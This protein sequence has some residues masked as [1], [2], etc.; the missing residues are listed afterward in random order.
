MPKRKTE[1]TAIKKSTKLETEVYDV[2]GKVVE[3]ISLPK[4]IFEAR[5]NTSLV[6]QAVR[7]Y[8]ANQRL[9]TAS[10]K[11]RGQVSGSTR[12]IYRQKGTGRARHGDIKAPIFIG[13]GIAHG[14]HPHDYNLTM[15]QKMRKM[16]LYG[17]ITDKF[18]NDRIKVI[19]GLENMP[20]KTKA[21]LEI[22][23][24]LGYIDKKDKKKSTVLLVIP[25]KM[26]N[27]YL[28]GRNLKCL[29]VIEVGQLNTYE[30]LTRQNL[31]F[32]K[33]AIDKLSGQKPA[34]AKK[35]IKKKSV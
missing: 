2:S 16:A 22:L 13:G 18:K 31:L 29:M 24:V 3:K 5:V 4:E 20:L 15:P 26:E 6:A 28:A 30:V 7:V 11:T 23:K 9:G 25:H 12:K 1:K 35:I 21:M 19:R 10:T 32:A 27:I 8:L 34:L 14:P 17:V 33:E